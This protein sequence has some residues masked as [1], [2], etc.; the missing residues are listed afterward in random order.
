M[1]QPTT[2]VYI[3]ER[4]REGSTGVYKLIS[5]P[6]K[7]KEECGSEE[8]QPAQLLTEGRDNS[9]SEAGEET[10]LPRPQAG[11]SCVLAKNRN[12]V[13]SGPEGGAGCHG[14]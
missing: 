5:G 12:S 14:S 13:S 10:A 4:A 8:R 3:S 1:C 6:I 11:R 9:Q 2:E 7:K